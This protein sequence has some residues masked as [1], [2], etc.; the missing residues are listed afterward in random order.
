MGPSA[1]AISAALAIFAQEAPASAIG[2]PDAARAALRDY[3]RCQQAA[4]RALDDGHSSED[5]IA[6]QMEARCEAQYQIYRQALSTRGGPGT[7]DETTWILDNQRQASARLAVHGYR[8]GVVKIADIK[9]CV[10]HVADEFKSEPFD[11]IVD[12]GVLRCGAM[13]PFP[14]PPIE[15][16]ATMT[17]QQIQDRKERQERAARTMISVQLRQIVSASPSQGN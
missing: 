15:R 5:A 10:S 12:Q 11:Q 13:V 2:P 4:A 1:L 3:S 6:T 7:P 17:E 8:R 14:V 9:S 16:Q